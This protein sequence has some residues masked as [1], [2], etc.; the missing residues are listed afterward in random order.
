MN[1]QRQ[2]G[3]GNLISILWLGKKVFVRSD[4][5]SYSY[6]KSEGF[7]VYD[8]IEINN[9]SFKDFISIEAY[10]AIKNKTLA[11]DV[12]SDKHYKELWNNLFSQK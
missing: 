9:I 4:T 1:H 6:F 11:L 10:D 7:A 3:L 8:T 12:F 2:Q 5:T